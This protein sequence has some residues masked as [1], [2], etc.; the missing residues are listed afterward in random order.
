MLN[1]FVKRT[2]LTNHFSSFI[3]YKKKD[4]R[5]KKFVEDLVLF[6]AKG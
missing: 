6:I 2:N 5:Q 3:P 4:S 1:S